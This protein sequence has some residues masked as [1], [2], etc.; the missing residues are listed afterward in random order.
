MTPAEISAEVGKRQRERLDRA[1]FRLTAFRP[2]SRWTNIPLIELFAEQGNRIRERSDG[3]LESGH[4]P[5][6]SSRSGRCVLIDK[7]AGIWFCRS[8]RHGG[9][10]AT[11]IKRLRGCRDADAM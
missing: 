10:A 5:F 8:C 2:S 6:H 7:T 3:R 4:E 1:T 11:L 9:D